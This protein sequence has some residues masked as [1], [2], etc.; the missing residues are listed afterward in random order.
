MFFGC[1]LKT[2]TQPIKVKNFSNS[3]EVEFG[4][5]S[6]HQNSKAEMSSWH[7]TLS[8]SLMK[9]NQAKYYFSTHCS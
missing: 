5:S 1:T 2:Y 4:G 3:C 6:L 9:Q 7:K 8:S